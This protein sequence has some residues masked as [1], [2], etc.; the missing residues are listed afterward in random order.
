[1]INSILSLSH[2]KENLP[3]SSFNWKHAETCVSDRNG[4]TLQTAGA[5]LECLGNSEKLL[6]EFDLICN[7]LNKASTLLPAYAERIHRA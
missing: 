3:G 5:L 2:Q 6:K 4:T 7:S 1:M